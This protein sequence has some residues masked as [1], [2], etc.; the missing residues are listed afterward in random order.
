LSVAPQDV[1]AS[2]DALAQAGET[3]MIVGELKPA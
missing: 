3:A 2:L 1:A